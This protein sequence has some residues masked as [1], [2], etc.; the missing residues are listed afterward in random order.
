MGRPAE[1]RASRATKHAITGPAKPTAL[2]ERAYDVA[3][4]R[5]D[6]GNADMEITARMKQGVPNHDDVVRRQ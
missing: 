3:C 1:S 4:G 2:G 6:I 5:L